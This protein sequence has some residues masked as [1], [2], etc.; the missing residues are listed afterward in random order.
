MLLLVNKNLPIFGFSQSSLKNYTTTEKDVALGIS[1]MPMRSLRLKEERIIPDTESSDEDEDIKEWIDEFDIVEADEGDKINNYLKKFNRPEDIEEEQKLKDDEKSELLFSKDPEESPDFEPK[2]LED[3]DI[4]QVID[5]GSFGKVFLVI[6]KLNGKY[7][8]MKRIRK[9]ILVKKKQVE[10]NK[11]EKEI[12]LNVKH[13]FL[14]G[15]DYVFQ[16][17]ERIYFFLDYIPGGN[18]FENLY[19]VKRFSEDVVKFIAA[20]LVIAFKCLHSKKIVHRDLKPENVLFQADGYIKLADFGLAKFLNSESQATYSFCGTAE[21]LAPEVLDQT[22]H[23]YTVDWWT[24]GILIYE[25]KTGRPPFLDKNNHK[26]GLLIRKG[27][28]VFP[29]P[30][31][32]KIEMSEEMKDLISKLLDRDPTN[33]LGINGH[34]EVMDHPWFSDIDFEAIENMEVKAPFKPIIKRKIYEKDR[35]IEEKSK[36]TFVG[37]A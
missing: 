17:E 12:L 27:K 18:L 25:L 28:I 37:F 15:M 29:D 22:G 36:E 2:S 3:F 26:L 31:K 16:N 21:Y 7:Y 13:P 34:Q 4:L 1:R 33:R 11:N 23:S 5:K 20:Q 6:N 35:D 32:H 30:I 19:S 9:D 8:A 24:L 10:N 14:L